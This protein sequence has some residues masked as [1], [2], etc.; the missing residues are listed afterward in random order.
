MDFINWEA[1]QKIQPLNGENGKLAPEP[2]WV[3]YES[4]KIDLFK[5]ISNNF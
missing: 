4:C 1:E 2:K 3:G 5:H